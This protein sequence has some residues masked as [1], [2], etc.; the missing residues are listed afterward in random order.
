MTTIDT[1][2]QF[3]PPPGHYLVVENRMD[4]MRH[5]ILVLNR[6]IDPD[7][8]EEVKVTLFN[9]SPHEYIISK[10]TKLAQIVA[11]PIVS[12]TC[13]PGV[14]IT[15]C[16]TKKNQGMDRFFETTYGAGSDK[17]RNIV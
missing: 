15:S 3:V 11:M 7:Y 17:V 10:G 14:I 12:V 6:S 9:A 4:L 16:D 1:L 8:R 2:V 5:S 13:K